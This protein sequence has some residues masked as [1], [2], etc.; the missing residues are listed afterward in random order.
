MITAAPQGVSLV[1]RHN[2]FGFA[3]AAVLESRLRASKAVRSLDLS[4]NAGMG[5][6]LV[7]VIEAC[8]V[9]P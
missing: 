5:D 9:S 8:T 3:A 2:Q 6:S 4:H 1:L 7:S